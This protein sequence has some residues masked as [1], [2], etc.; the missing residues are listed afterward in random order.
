[1]QKKTVFDNVLDLAGYIKGQTA[2]PSLARINYS[3]YFLWS[4]YAGTFGNLGAVP[5]DTPES[6]IEPLTF[7]EMLFEPKFFNAQFGPTDLEI[8]EAYNS[9]QIPEVT[10]ADLRKSMHLNDFGTE[11]I[12]TFIDNYLKQLEEVD[13]YELITLAMTDPVVQNS[14]RGQYMNPA[15][16]KAS[17]I[18]QVGSNAK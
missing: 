15:E 11:N 12:I 7:P 18:K 13:E 6:L 14:L 10:A 9:D 16:I 17:Y 4:Y 3:L 5:E 2:D 8:N 1:M